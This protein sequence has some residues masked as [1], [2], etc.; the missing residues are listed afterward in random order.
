MP[1]C[2]ERT[3]LALFDIVVSFPVREIL[4]LALVAVLGPGLSTSSSSRCSSFVPQFSARAQMRCPSGS[5]SRK[6]SAPSGRRPYCCQCAVRAIVG[7]TAV[8]ASM[9]ILVG[10]R[11]LR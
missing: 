1:T 5:A 9:N 3:I 2:V 4:A 8:F 7:P 10:H 11:R 6:L